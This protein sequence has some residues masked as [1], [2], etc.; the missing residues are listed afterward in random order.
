MSL[1]V[2]PMR[3]EEAVAVAKM[4]HGLAVHIGTDFV[5]KLDGEG[6]RD[7]E[8]LIDVVVAEEEGRLLGA[9]LGLMTFS[10]WRGARGLYVVDL[11][12]LPEARGR[13]VGLDLL[14]CS[15]RRFA[16]RGARFIKLEVD[17]T[18]TG[19]ERF[20][21]RLGFVKKTEDRLHIL[22]QDGLRQFISAG[23]QE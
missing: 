19:A 22:E 11:F 3:R 4:V 2:R 14:R 9:C 8:D 13:N 20:Y 7:A 16:K 15:A 18:N 17:E 21:A 1:S 23:G 12:V 6:L 5:P 10:T